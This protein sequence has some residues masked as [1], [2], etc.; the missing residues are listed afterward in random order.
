MLGFLKSNKNTNWKIVLCFIFLV[1][2]FGI[3]NYNFQILSY[4]DFDAN[5]VKKSTLEEYDS[6]ANIGKVFDNY[7]ENPKWRSYKVGIQKFVDFQ[8][9]FAL[10]NEP[11]DAVLT[12]YLLEDKFDLD[13]IKINNREI[14]DAMHDGFLKE[15]YG[16]K[17]QSV[18]D[19]K[20][21]FENL[22]LD[23]LYESSLPEN[24]EIETKVEEADEYLPT[25]TEKDTPEQKK[26]EEIQ[27]V[28]KSVNIQPAKPSS[29]EI[30]KTLREKV[31]E[32]EVYADYI[33]TVSGG[34][35]RLA[36]SVSEEANIISDH[37]LGFYF[38]LVTVFENGQDNAHT[39]DYFYVS[40]DLSTVFWYE[41]MNTNILPLDEW[42]R[43]RH[44]REITI[45]NTSTPYLE[46][47]LP[48][49]DSMLY[50]EEAL[51]NLTPKEL[52]IARNE[53]Y[54]RYGRMFNDPELQEHFNNCSWYYGY[55][56]PENF[57][58]DMLN[59]FEA[60]NRTMIV[61][62]EERMGY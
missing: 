17:A 48:Y 34:D 6:N 29:D 61:K 16:I 46:Y 31:P 56:S 18:A 49:S 2:A 3:A 42:R 60:L 9:G 23:S 27:F 13:S 8:G 53:V 51:Y 4:L 20:S 28:D 38:Y 1:I 62:Y 33:E 43:S 47:V 41:G 52:K 45:P 26:E 21:F 5:K 54:A 59:Q 32:L 40:E 30:T 37:M 14:P 7:F 12:F 36:I 55:I 24:S 15:V 22:D 39:W 25:T 11:A 10:H 57:S 35:S 44:Y 19:K 50:S 58:D